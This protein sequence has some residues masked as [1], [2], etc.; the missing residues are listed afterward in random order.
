MQI[1]SLDRSIDA[2]ESRY[3][4]GGEVGAGFGECAGCIRVAIIIPIAMDSR[5]NTAS[6]P[7]LLKG[8]SLVSTPATAT[9]LS[10]PGTISQKDG[11]K[12]AM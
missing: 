7:K 5:V 6:P 10:D 12:S 9:K 2:G 4:V 1:L 3:G 11:R 8:A